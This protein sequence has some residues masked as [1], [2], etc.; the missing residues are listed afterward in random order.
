MISPRKS[1]VKAKTYQLPFSVNTL[2]LKTASMALDDQDFIQHVVENV[3]IETKFLQTELD[4]MGIE[5]RVCKSNFLLMKIEDQADQV[6]QELQDRDVLLRNL[7]KYPLLK[8]YL[9]ISIGKREDNLKLLD[10][11]LQILPFEA[12]LFDMDGVLVDVSKSY[13]LAIKKTAE[14]FIDET[15]SLEEISAFKDKG[16]LNNDWYLTREIVQSHGKHV[17]ME[18]IIE[19]FQQFY[20]GDNYNGLIQNEKWLLN[21]NILNQLKKKYRLGIVTGRPRAEAEFVLQRFGVTNHFDVLITMNDIPLNKGKPDPFS[22]NMAL[23]KL[24]AKQA[25][26]LGDNIDDM[27]A[28]RAANIIAIGV[29]NQNSDT[30]QRVKLLEQFGAKTV[31]G[32]VNE[33]SSILK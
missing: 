1:M 18:Q 11:L 21:L 32:S 27:K 19:I 29:L 6:Y 3:A 15:I 23:E 22:I 2:A 7:N 17:Q 10:T 28:A 33:V 12:I 20:L 13:R 16:G 30:Q 25:I 26:Y 8:G 31:L 4:K 14:Y 5:T 24:D 9:R